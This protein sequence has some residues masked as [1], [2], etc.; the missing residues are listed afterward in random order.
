MASSLHVSPQYTVAAPMVATNTYKH[1]RNPSPGNVHLE[2][3]LREV[4][5]PPSCVPD[6]S[7]WKPISTRPYLQPPPRCLRAVPLDRWPGDAGHWV[8][9]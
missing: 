5:V 4:F 1:K 2:I 6:R 8:L 3:L 9:L 7:P